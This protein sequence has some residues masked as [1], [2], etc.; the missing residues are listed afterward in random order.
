MSDLIQNVQRSCSFYVVLILLYFFA[1][2]VG[3]VRGNDE[4]HF[5]TQKLKITFT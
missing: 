4:S 5:I 3:G 2:G 1:R